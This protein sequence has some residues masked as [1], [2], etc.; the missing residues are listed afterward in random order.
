MTN[1]WRHINQNNCWN[2]LAQYFGRF[3]VVSL[4]T[5]AE[6]LFKSVASNYFKEYSSHFN[7]TI[8]RIDTHGSI[9]YQPNGN[10]FK[11]NLRK[12]FELALNFRS[13]RIFS[14]LSPDILRDDQG[15]LQAYER[16]NQLGC[17]SLGSRILA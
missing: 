8:N 16:G 15:G 17:R 13:F 11:A 1:C 7:T 6:L 5:A 2:Q 4:K 14:L 12:P 3:C 9:F 10:E